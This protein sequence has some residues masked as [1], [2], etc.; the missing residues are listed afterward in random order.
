MDNITEHFQNKHENCSVQSR[1]KTDPDYEPS[2]LVLRNPVAI[3]LLRKA[4]QQTDVYKFPQNF[5]LAMDTYYVESFNYVL[6]IFL[7]KRIHFGSSTYKLRTN[8][9]VFHWNENVDRQFTNVWTDPCGNTIRK[10]YTK[11]SLDYRGR[12]WSKLMSLYY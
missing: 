11:R 9:A 3:D 5:V 7:D 1:C 12:I 10:S 6:N 4:I 8:L 2:K